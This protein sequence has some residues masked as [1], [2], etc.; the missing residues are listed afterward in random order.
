MLCVF[1][2]YNSSFCI[3]YS[4]KHKKE[5]IQGKT[6]LCII[7]VEFKIY[8]NTSGHKGKH[9]AV[10]IWIWQNKLFPAV[11][12]IQSFFF[13]SYYL[14][15]RQL[16][17]F[18]PSF[19]M[20]TMKFCLCVLWGPVLC[21]SCWC[22]CFQCRAGEPSGWGLVRWSSPPPQLSSSS[23]QGCLWPPAATKPSARATSAS[24]S[25]R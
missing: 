23:Y 25:S 20:S 11:L 21:V 15:M 12:H 3:M 16:Q 6:A 1:K 19:G 14:L 7:V 4:M 5:V 2:H 8:S 9:F 18:F 22:R 17:L 24:V 13:R 10:E